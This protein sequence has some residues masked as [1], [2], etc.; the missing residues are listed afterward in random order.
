[1]PPPISKKSRRCT[2]LEIA[3][4]LVGEMHF[5]SSWK[6][7]KLNRLSLT[8]CLPISIENLTTITRLDVHLIN[9]TA[10]TL[11]H[12]PISSGCSQGP[13]SMPPSSQLGSTRSLGSPLQGF[14]QVVSLEN[15]QQLEFSCCLGDVAYGMIKGL[16]SFSRSSPL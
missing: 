4:A 7:P 3:A 2:A 5:F 10:N 12:L 16:L 6:M 15:V 8:D 13:L 9:S 14:S 1:M 11:Y